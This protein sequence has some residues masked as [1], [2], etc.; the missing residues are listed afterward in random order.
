MMRL[1]KIKV[2][3]VLSLIFFALIATINLKRVN[4]MSIWIVNG[5]QKFVNIIPMGTYWNVLGL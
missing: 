5:K 2:Q 3:E 4:K 1:N